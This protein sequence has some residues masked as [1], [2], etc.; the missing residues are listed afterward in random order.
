M[1]TLMHE[2]LRAFIKYSGLSDVEFGRRFNSTGK[3]I[4]NWATGT[5]MNLGRMGDMLQAYPE[6]N[7]NW[8]LTGFG[9]MLNE[10]D[11]NG[12]PVPRKPMTEEEYQLQIAELQQ[13]LL[14]LMEEKVD[15]LTKKK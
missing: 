8:L 4:G 13:K 7:S 2:R 11:K 15:W 9:D 12:V 5:A 10:M 1:K 3:E 14:Q 6:L